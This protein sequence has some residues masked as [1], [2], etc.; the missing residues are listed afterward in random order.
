MLTDAAHVIFQSAKRRCYIVSSPSKPASA[1]IDLTEDNDAWAALDEAEGWTT[2]TN[3][4][5]DNAK[6]DWLPE[7]LEPIL[8]ELPKWNLL[9]EILI[10]AESEIIR[11]E[12]LRRPGS[13]CE[14]LSC[15]LNMVLN[16]ASSKRFFQRH[17]YHGV[18]KSYM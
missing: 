14:F 6:P 15:L 11:Q 12:S 5:G 13:I 9:S 10:E 3:K 1:T 16:P 4:D 18:F 17:S 8:E 2:M 7:G